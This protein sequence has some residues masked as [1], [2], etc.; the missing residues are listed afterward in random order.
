[1]K[2]ILVLTDFSIRADN[3]AHYALKLAQKIKA[4]LLVCNVFLEPS[5]QPMAS[6]V[7]WPM[8]TY[9]TFEEDSINDVSELAGR[10]NKQ[11]DKD[12]ADGEFRPVIEQSS[13]AGFVANGLNEIVAAHHILMA[14]MSIHSTDNLSTFL[15]GD[16]AWEIIEKA[17]CPVLLVPYQETFNG[18]KKIAFGTDLA[19]SDIDVLHCLSGFAKYLNFEILIAHV[20]AE[21]SSDQEEQNLV[22]HFLKQVSSAI[23]Y[24]M[25]YYRA[26]YNA[27]VTTGLHWLSQHSD[28]DMLV[29]VHHKRGFFQR[30][31]GGSISQNLAEHP[32]IPLLVFPFPEAK[33][34]LPVF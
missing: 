28:I 11:L 9:E 31:F 26:I 23:N 19:D 32:N 13:I 17:N 3:A 30:L 4:N 18:Y 1:M 7:P 8:E 25:I 24:P 33:R 5:A 12:V 34:S 14:V 22:K 6:Q 2:T 21:R 29:V 20:T 10:L 15:L 27:H 16:H